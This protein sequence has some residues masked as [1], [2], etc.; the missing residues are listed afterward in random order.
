MY[1]Y[2]NISTEK[3]NSVDGTKRK[4]D[5]NRK[6]DEVRCFRNF[7]DTCLTNELHTFIAKYLCVLNLLAMNESKV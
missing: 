5:N 2:C 3:E 7:R 4:E 1:M 6:Q